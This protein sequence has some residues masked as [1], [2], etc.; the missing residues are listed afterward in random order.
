[1]KSF[2]QPI[3]FCGKLPGPTI[4]LVALTHWNEPVGLSLFEKLLQAGMFDRI[5]IGK[6]ILVCSNV[7]AHEVYLKQDNPLKFRFIDHDMNRIWNDSFIE[8]SNEYKRR[9]EMKTILSQADIILDIH[10]V[11]KG[12]DVLWI[13]WNYWLEDAIQFMDVQKILV[14]WSNTGSMRSYLEKMGK[15]AY[16]IEAWNHISETGLNNGLR[17]VKNM[18]HH[19][20]IIF[21]DK[22]FEFPIPEKLAFISE[23]QPTVREFRYA[24]DFQNWEQISKWE[25]Y[26]YDGENNPLSHSL[27]WDIRI[28]LV[29]KQIQ[30]G[31]GAGFLFRKI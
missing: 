29:Q 4:A 20:G 5:Q 28:G 27:E 26:A 21:S 15:R 22:D 23:L 25:T 12:D 9:E 18:L 13:A 8:N 19:F 10:S 16:G 31:R 14:E 2:N 17:I 11:S 6:I 30:F 24:R 3:I 7:Q 1:M